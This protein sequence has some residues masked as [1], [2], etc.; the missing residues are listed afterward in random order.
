MK[1]IYL[2]YDNDDNLIAVA[3][4]VQEL[5]TILDVKKRTI[6]NSLNY[7]RKHP[8]QQRFSKCLK[9]YKYEKDY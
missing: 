7:R 9:Y 3:D 4:S 6:T 8:E 5:A 2:A 1:Y